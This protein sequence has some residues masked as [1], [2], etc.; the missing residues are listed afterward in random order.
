M[1]VTGFFAQCLFVTLLSGLWNF[2]ATNSNITA[3][4]FF[5]DIGRHNFINVWM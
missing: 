5:T 2:A 3:L 4:A 1:V